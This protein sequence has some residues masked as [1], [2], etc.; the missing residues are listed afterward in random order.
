MLNLLFSDAYIGAHY[1]SYVKSCN[2][3]TAPSSFP[4]FAR[5]FKTIKEECPSGGCRLKYPCL[6]ISYYSGEN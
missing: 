1:T 6:P 2:F 5:E 4:T 3:C